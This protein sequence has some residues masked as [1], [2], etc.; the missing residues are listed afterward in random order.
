MAALMAKL[1]VAQRVAQRAVDWVA[2]L[3]YWMVGWT[4]ALM[5]CLRVAASAV[6][7]A[8]YWA[9]ELDYM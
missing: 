2:L 7:L 8:E 5:V 1:P 3:V 4:D 6:L 9:A